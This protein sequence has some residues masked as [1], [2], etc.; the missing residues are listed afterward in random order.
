MMI[1][2]ICHCRS[3]YCGN[4]SS[5]G[6]SF[7]SIGRHDAGGRREPCN[8]NQLSHNGISSE[9]YEFLWFLTGART[10]G[11]S[12]LVHNEVSALPHENR[13]Y[14]DR[15]PMSNSTW[16]SVEDIDICIAVCSAGWA[17]QFVAGLAAPSA[18]GPSFSS[19]LVG[20]LAAQGLL[21]SLRRLEIIWSM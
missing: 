8:N 7:S 12:N 5:A 9:L 20:T 2:K 16:P 18:G 14:R 10:S 17:R 4:Y 6:L 11:L 3:S 13:N 15:F 21:L 1:L 19:G